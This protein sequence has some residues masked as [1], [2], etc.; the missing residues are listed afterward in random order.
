MNNTIVDNSCTGGGGGF[1]CKDS[2]VPVLI[3]N[4]IYSNIQYGGE[5][6]QVYLWDN[7]SQPHFYHNNIQGG[8]AAFA[9]SGGNDFTGKYV[10]NIDQDPLFEEDSYVP[11]LLS[12]C[13][14]SGRLDTLGLMI[15]DF[16]LSGNKRIVADT[17]DM[18]AFEQQEVLGIFKTNVKDISFLQVYPNPVCGKVQIEFELLSPEYIELYVTDMWG[19]KHEKLCEK[20]MANGRHKLS[21]DL[22][23][24]PSSNYLIVLKTG[25][26]SQARIIIKK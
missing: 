6:N 17:I 2:V 9:G 11:S 16:D 20:E 18:G 26:A 12:P 25:K 3:N 4:I 1:Y 14:N 13:V 5:I 22:K 19:N 23:G 24:Y 15:P 10:N 7:L 8:I 21:Y